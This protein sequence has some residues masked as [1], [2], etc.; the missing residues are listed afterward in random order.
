MAEP[1]FVAKV[2]A[3][4]VFL[5]FDGSRDQCTALHPLSVSLMATVKVKSED[6]T[7]VDGAA[8]WDQSGAAGKDDMVSWHLPRRALD[9]TAF[10]IT[11]P[12]GKFL[13]VMDHLSVSAL[14]VA[15]CLYAIFLGSPSV[16][17]STSMLL[18]KVAVACCKHRSLQTRLC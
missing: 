9:N 12:I 16:D 10:Q 14:G 1:L 4:F 18:P 8:K 5:L 6:G 17:A 2:K 13:Y 11:D 3:G 15:V 7:C